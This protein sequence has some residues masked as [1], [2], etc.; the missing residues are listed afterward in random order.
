MCG[1]SRLFVI[2]EALN[3]AQKAGC[4]CYGRLIRRS[5]ARRYIL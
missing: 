3:K 1:I 5:F 4:A 2:S